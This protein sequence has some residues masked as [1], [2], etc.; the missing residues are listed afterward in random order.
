MNKTLKKAL[1]FGFSGALLGGLGLF[2]K[3]VEAAA[4]ANNIGYSVQSIQ[5]DKQVKESLKQSYFDMQLDAKAEET[6]SVK[7]FN[8]S[9]KALKIRNAVYTASTNDNGQLEYTKKLEKKDID[10]SMKY[11]LASLTKMDSGSVVTV[12]AKGSK[13]VKATITMPK[14]SFDGVL[15]G[16][17]YFEKVD[18]SAKASSNKKGIS[19]SNAYS[20]AIGIKILEKKTVEPNM[21]LLSV[22]AGMR[23][24]RKGVFPV[25]QND[26]AVIIPKLTIKSQIMKKGSSTVLQETTLKNLSMAPNSN[27]KFPMLYDKGQLESG[28]YTLKAVATSGKNTW[29]FNK[30]FTITNDDA[31][32]YNKEAIAD[33]KKPMNPL[34]YVALGL[35]LAILFVLIFFLIKRYV[36]KKKADK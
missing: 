2:N 36:D 34:W 20:Y 24:Y 9:D 21:N 17:W 22:K 35:G 30:N 19:I 27:F 25:F 3:S 6:I 28:D 11:P 8:S 15:L 4:P 5:S 26:T 32:K 7:I 31:S 33:P 10:K 23:N 13:I 16:S 29:N 1:L 18:D 12:P 14:D